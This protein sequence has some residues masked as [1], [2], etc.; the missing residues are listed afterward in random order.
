VGTCRAGLGAAA[1]LG[2]VWAAALLASP[3]AAADTPTPAVPPVPSTAA[4]P[5]SS[6]PPAT[7]SCRLTITVT[8]NPNGTY[9][10]GGVLSSSATNA[11]V[12][13]ITIT[14][15]AGDVRAQATTDAQGGYQANLT[16]TKAGEYTFE[17]AAATTPLCPGGATASQRATVVAPVELTLQSDVTTIAAGGAV[18]VSGRLTSQDAGVEGAYLTL[19]TSFDSSSMPLV[20]SA[21]GSFN[22][23]VN[24]P[25]TGST[26]F[27]I[28]VTFPGDG[29]LP[30][31]SHQVSVIVTD[32]ASA[33][34]TASR[35][36]SA[37][38]SAGASAES[39][40]PAGEE[41]TEDA[42]A[43]PWET[44]SRLFV[45]LLIFIVVA[46]LAVGTLLIIGVV[47]RQRR[48]LAADER[49]GFGSDFG[50]VM[51]EDDDA[52]LDD[53]LGGEGPIIDH[54]DPR[55]R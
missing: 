24:G 52:G 53:L 16:M 21:D 13:G 34:P 54:Q 46:A 33:T 44:G 26:T 31:T 32:A 3:P 7:A 6:A 41:A 48:G 45:V 37:A 30:G 4:S 42:V 19:T 2:A 43:Q 5:A 27:T 15:A 36:A 22:A 18:G 50:K 11:G 12:S 40:E 8:A 17:A 29:Y 39:E 55:R 51:D 20:T 10:A 49:R 23:V 1:A 14:V 25:T 38:P 47:S 9:T 28:T 35:S